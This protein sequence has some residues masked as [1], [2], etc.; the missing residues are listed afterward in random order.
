[1]FKLKNFV[2]IIL[3]LL[4]TALALLSG[5]RDEKDFVVNNFSIKR[6]DSAWD[7][8]RNLKLENITESRF[9]FLFT[10]YKKGLQKDIKAGEYV[11]NSKL[12]NQEIIEII[13][14]GKIVEDTKTIKVTFPEGWNSV[15]M[16]ERLDEKGFSGRD[17]LAFVGKPNYFLEKYNFEF[18]NSLPK[19][20]SMEGFLFPD[21]YF[22]TENTTESDIVKK[23]LEN[24]D[25]KFSLDLKNE[26]Q[27]QGKT[28]YEIVT[29]ASLI[30]KE[31]RNDKD[32]K[33][34]SGVFWNRLEIG[35]AL[36]SCATLA[37]IRGDNK[38]QYSY[39]DTQID[40]PYNTY[41]YPGLPPGPISNPGLD[42]IRAAIYPEETDYIYFLSNVNTGETVFSRT[43]KEHNFNKDKN[44]L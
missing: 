7:V 43:L 38:M 35:Q 22:L 30:E 26:T 44:G 1:M 11:L 14:K 29:L 42:S 28:L 39:E 2:I 8:S 20:E 25:D 34:V 10:I 27:R 6:G 33:L 16:A 5:G 40:S 3:V 23:M 41:L 21:T 9:S 12:N 37:F 36:Q 17:F 31:V 15:Q 32:R 24:F 4:L 13:T 18:L 19:G